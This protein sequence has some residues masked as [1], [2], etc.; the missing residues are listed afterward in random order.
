MLWRA[1]A[2]SASKAGA[3]ACATCSRAVAMASTGRAGSAPTASTRLRRSRS[4]AMPRS[5]PLAS[6]SSTEDTP[7]VRMRAAASATEVP[8]LTVTGAWRSRLRS[9]CDINVA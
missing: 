4:V 2:S 9:G 5:R 7:C 8:G 3:S 1:M 6:T